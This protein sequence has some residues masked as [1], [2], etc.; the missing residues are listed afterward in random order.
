MRSRVIVFLALAFGLG[1]MASH[2]R[3][4][5]TESNPGTV[6]HPKA[7]SLWA[8]G[9]VSRISQ[10]DKFQLQYVP[11]WS[12]LPGRDSN[13]LPNNNSQSTR[14]AGSGWIEITIDAERQ[15]QEHPNDRTPI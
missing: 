11:S 9:T 7:V 8:L 13:L 5:D 1:M 12:V 4:A 2:S 10:W 15:T 14:E 6:V 3:G